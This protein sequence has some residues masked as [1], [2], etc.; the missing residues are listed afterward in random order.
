MADLRLR[1]G[2]HVRGPAGH[3][4]Q[5]CEGRYRSN[6]TRPDPAGRNA[7]KGLPGRRP[8][9]SGAARWPVW[10]DGLGRALMEIGEVIPP[11]DSGRDAFSR[12]RYQAHAVFLACLK[13]ASAS[14]PSAVI[15]EHIEDVSMM[16]A[17]RFV[18]RQINTRKPDY[19]GW[20]LTELC[21]SSGALCSIPPGTPSDQGSR[22]PSKR[23]TRSSWRASRP[24][25]LDPQPLARR[26]R[27]GRGSGQAPSS[28]RPRTP[29]S[30][31]SKRRAKSFQAGGVYRPPPRS[32]RRRKPPAP[33]GPSRPSARK[34]ARRDL[35]PRGR[36]DLS[37]DGRNACRR[38]MV[39]GLF[40]TDGGAADG[41]DDKCLD[42]ETLCGPLKP[43]V[44]GS[45]RPWWD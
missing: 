17:D 3:R 1:T 6:R 10:Q 19:G 45:S 42:A 44:T 20:R 34:G 27:A 39:N 7:T 22:G 8:S 40:A 26:A 35:R 33:R 15:C 16:E 23:C 12:L 43:A 32:N 28:R 2:P 38:Q 9:E 4:R 18:L 31:P 41:V 24:G 36:T 5:R 21:L 25:R 14:W 13:S 37:G 29:T 11:D 30:S